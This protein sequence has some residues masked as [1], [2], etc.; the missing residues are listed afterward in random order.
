MRL[1]TQNRF[2]LLLKLLS[3]FGKGGGIAGC[4]GEDWR[5]RSLIS[6]PRMVNFSA[7]PASGRSPPLAP[8]CSREINLSKLQARLA[9]VSFASDRARSMTRKNRPNLFFQ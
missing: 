2:A 6:D 7:I 4:E 5:P 8:T 9:R 3:D 1:R